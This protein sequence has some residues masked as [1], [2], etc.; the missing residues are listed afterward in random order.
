MKVLRF[1]L[2]PFAVVYNL[3]TALRNLFFD[4]GILKSTS[5]KILKARNVISSKFPIG[6]GT[7]YNLLMLQSY[8]KVLLHLWYV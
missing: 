2:F 8:N 4:V 6:V 3:I 5:F 1:L 7:K